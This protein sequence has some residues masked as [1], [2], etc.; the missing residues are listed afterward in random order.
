MGDPAR[1]QPIP[2]QRRVVLVDEFARSDAMAAG[3]K[4]AVPLGRRPD[5]QPTETGAQQSSIKALG[6]S[7]AVGNNAGRPPH[8]VSRR[9][10]SLLL[11]SRTAELGKSSQ[12]PRA[13][14]WRARW[15]LISADGNGRSGA[16]DYAFDQIRLYVTA[17]RGRTT[18]R[19]V[20]G[21]PAIA[22]PRPSVI[23]AGRH[24]LKA[25][26]TPSANARCSVT[27]P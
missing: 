5:G 10:T 23:D 2:L 13:G 15:A 27:E 25:E 11:G 26:A 1:S 4:T 20:S 18:K 3:R 7:I 9:T 16:G 14:P 12:R 17:S 6:D 24:L 19:I 8:Y 21:R 22:P